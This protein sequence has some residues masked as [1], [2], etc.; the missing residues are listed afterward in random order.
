M[1]VIHRYLLHTSKVS[2]ARLNTE[3]KWQF[4]K[5]TLQQTS[6]CWA[7]K[8]CVNHAQQPTTARCSNRCIV[9]QI[10]IVPTAQYSDNRKTFAPT[11]VSFNHSCLISFHYRLQLMICF[12]VSYHIS[13]S[14]FFWLIYSIPLE[15]I[16]FLFSFSIM[17]N[18]RIKLQEKDV[19]LWIFHATGEDK[20]HW[21]LK[22]HNSYQGRPW[23]RT[24]RRLVSVLSD[25]W[26]IR[27][28]GFVL[29]Q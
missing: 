27:G 29:S 14:C 11:P 18:V 28:I 8:F 19:T 12:Y 2:H 16:I 25:Q 26:G 20:A 13:C 3:Y 4:L 17:V 7:K 24:G 22:R 15:S 23:P 10:S 21:A 6:L 1:S 9:R 5:I